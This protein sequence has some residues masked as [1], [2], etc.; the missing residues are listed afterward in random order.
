MKFISFFFSYQ[1][2]LHQLIRVD[3]KIYLQLKEEI[4]LIEAIIENDT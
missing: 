3:M 2:E 4:K 1:K